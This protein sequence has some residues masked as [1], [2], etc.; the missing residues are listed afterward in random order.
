MI[1]RGPGDSSAG[2][3]SRRD[4]RALDWI[5]ERGELILPYYDYIILWRDLYPVHGGF[6]DYT[7]DTLGIFSFSN[8]LW[9]RRQYFNEAWTEESPVPDE[10]QQLFY[11]DA[12]G[13]G[14][15]YVDWHEVEHPQY[16]T[17]EVG[18]FTKYFGR[19][20]PP[21]MLQE[22][23]HRNAMFALFHADQMPLVEMGEVAVERIGG[24]TWQV[25]A[26]A[27]N[28]RII[29]TRADAARRNRVGLPD[30]FTLEGRNVE[31]TLGGFVAGQFGELLQP[32][33]KNPARIVL[34]SGID[35]LTTVTVRWI[36]TGSGQVT[37]TY[38]SQKGGTVSRTVDLR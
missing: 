16:G 38:E 32:V 28:A 27:R 22:L 35:G 13:M 10:Q 17:V 11:N 14:A 30:F 15:W 7:Y 18:G 21:F 29:P 25:T 33:E 34:E 24:D 37:L 23:C 20:T 12:V 8:E 26:E 4:L 3:Y 31:V 9:S 5:G 19:M 6:I 36:V 1:L 2:D